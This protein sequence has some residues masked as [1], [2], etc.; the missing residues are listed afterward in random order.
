MADII[1]LIKKQSA[2][3]VAE[4]SEL[5]GRLSEQLKHLINLIPE[6]TRQKSVEDFL[7]GIRESVLGEAPRKYTRRAKKASASAPKRAK[8]A[9]AGKGAGRRGRKKKETMPVT[10]EQKQA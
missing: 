1:K 7:N 6:N 5:S 2:Q 4:L 10:E 9:K 3:R 8:K